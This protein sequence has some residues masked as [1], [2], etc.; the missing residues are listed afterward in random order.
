M[1]VGYRTDH[2]SVLG[3]TR[4]PRRDVRGPPPKG[5]LRWERPWILQARRPGLPLRLGVSG[6]VDVSNL[7]RTGACRLRPLP[8]WPSTCSTLQRRLAV[9]R[10]RNALPEAIKGICKLSSDEEYIDGDST[11]RETL[12]ECWFL[13]LAVL[14]ERSTEQETVGTSSFR[15]VAL[16]CSPLHFGAGGHCSRMCSWGLREWLCRGRVRLWGG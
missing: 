8:S 9:P 16:A 12:V 14:H 15:G 4:G 2:F 7:R 10:P 3:P 5:Q 1:P 11:E 6:Q 13:A